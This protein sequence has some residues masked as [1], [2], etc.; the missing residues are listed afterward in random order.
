MTELIANDGA[1]GV[2]VMIELGG[3]DESGEKALFR[4]EGLLVERPDAVGLV[5][6]E[7]NPE[8]MAVTQV[9]MRV[10]ENSLTVL[11]GG[12]PFTSMLFRQGQTCESEY[13]ADGQSVILRTFPTEVSV[14]RRGARGRIHVVYQVT[15]GL[16]GGS[17]S[18]TGLRTLDVRFRPL[19]APRVAVKPPRAVRGDKPPKKRAEEAP[20]Q[21]E[22]GVAPAKP[23]A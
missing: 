7:I 17:L 22:P 9:M 2:R 6:Q 10:E 5:Y 16:L 18:E 14:R 20:A 8:D 4:T 19:D 21:V 11:R 12:E 13:R 23:I 3:R 15:A 1:D